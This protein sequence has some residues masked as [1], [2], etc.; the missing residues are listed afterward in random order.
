MQ[1]RQFKMSPLSRKKAF[2]APARE[3]RL[4]Q[5]RTVAQTLRSACPSISLVTV[6]LDFL[7]D[8]TLTHAAQSFSLYP[9]ARAVFCYP[10]PYG[11]CDGIYDLSA[12][13][14]QALNRQKPRVTGISRCSGTRSRIGQPKTGCGLSVRYTISAKHAADPP[15]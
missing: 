8:A 3:Q 14:D 6:K 15:A 13:A 5:I 12:E 1:P 7:A 4:R 10:C 9:S 2:D 11:D